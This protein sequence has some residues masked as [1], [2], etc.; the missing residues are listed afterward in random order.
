MANPDNKRRSTRHFN[1][2]KSGGR[3]FNIEKEVV[4]PKASSTPQPSIAP[5]ATGTAEESGNEGG[6][7][8]KWMWIIG[9]IL[10]VAIIAWLCV[11]GC[12]SSNDCESPKGPAAEVV[13]TSQNLR[14][15]SSI[16]EVSSETSLNIDVGESSP[17]SVAN[18]VDSSVKATQTEVTPTA[19]PS[20]ETNSKYSTSTP[21]I[22]IPTAKN[23]TTNDS[24]S[25]RAN[26]VSSDTETEAMK[27][28]RGDYGVGQERKDK[29]GTQYQTIQNRVNQLKREGAF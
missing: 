13:D 19:S 1:L 3:H 2:E 7:S 27:V 21:V 17:V 29:L 20:S 24:S 6:G 8:N 22:E 4:T 23:N 28:I 11:R 10:V 26:N 14:D 12:S 25:T 18:A 5:I 16:D 9:A 15:A